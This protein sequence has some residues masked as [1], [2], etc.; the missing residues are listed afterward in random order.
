MGMAHGSPR[1]TVLLSPAIADP[2]QLCEKL[3][4][5]MSHKQWDNWVTRDIAYPSPAICPGLPTPD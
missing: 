2:G 5:N 1:R 3:A 4:T